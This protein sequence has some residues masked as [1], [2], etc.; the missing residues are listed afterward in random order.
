MQQSESA[1]RDGSTGPRPSFE[2]SSDRLPVVVPHGEQPQSVMT[3]TA[4]R[5]GTAAR[6]LA[7]NPVAVAS[8]SAVATVG[9]GVVLNAARAALTR[10]PAPTAPVQVQVIHHVVHHV[11]HHVSHTHLPSG[12]RQ[13]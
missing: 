13:D 7:Q 5:L 1:D 8:A 4:A 3:R 11:V 9:T 10:A 12:N 2:G 6:A